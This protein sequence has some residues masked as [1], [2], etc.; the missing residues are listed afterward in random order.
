M[1]DP[2][3][4][5]LVETEGMYLVQAGH[6][7]PVTWFSTEVKARKEAARRALALGEPAY[8]F[9]AIACVKIS[10]DPVDWT[11]YNQD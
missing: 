2:L 8:V 3:E 9:R 5:L 7:G 11:E 1:V 4:S 10:S 6:G